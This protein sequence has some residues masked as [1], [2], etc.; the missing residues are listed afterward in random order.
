MWS[1][2]IEYTDFFPVT[3]MENTVVVMWIVSLAYIELEIISIIWYETSKIGKMSSR[4]HV[5]IWLHFLS[6]SCQKMP[7]NFEFF[8][9]LLL[10]LTAELIFSEVITVKCCVKCCVARRCWP[11]LGRKSRLQREIAYNCDKQGILG[12]I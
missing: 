4:H 8:L 2:R 10:E 3:F 7:P 1:Y 6:F 5:Q 9:F 11:L 12:V